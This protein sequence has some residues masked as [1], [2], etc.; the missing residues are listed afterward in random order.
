MNRRQLLALGVAAGASAL[1]KFE[2]R[3]AEGFGWEEA[4]I[5]KMREALGS[6]GTT[7]AALAEAY[8]GRIATLDKVG[9]AINSVIEI[10]PDAL[11]I[12]TALDEE[13][14]SKG[15]RGPLHGVPVMVKDNLDTN[16]R[17]M[18]TAGSLAMLGSIAPR[19]SFVV[20]K[21]REAGAVLLGKTNLS[22]W[23]NFR[24]SRS[25]SG[26]SARGGL[27]KNPY[28]LDR[29]PSGS[30][31]GSAV[32]VAAGL[33]AAAIGTETNGSILSPS[34]VCGVVGLKP[35][36]GLVSRAGIIPISSSQ[37]TAGPMARSVRDVA[38]ILGAIAGPDDRDPATAASQPHAHADY[39]QFLD[40]DGLRGARI[41]LPRQFFRIGAKAR[42]VI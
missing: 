29:N 30:S 1:V 39:T 19:D 17:M 21:L 32:A 41:G 8:L 28:A 6:G 22:E 27:T 34:T 14:K 18:T 31:S 10:N 13:R 37:D 20:Q 35:T 25:T 16:D 5:S 40:R 36:V 23:A 2:A 42:E 26:W 11:S 12:A 24:G 38:M 7:A 9:P 33:C 4:P 3:G 15:A